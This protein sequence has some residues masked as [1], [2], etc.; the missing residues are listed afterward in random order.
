[1]PIFDMVERTM[2]KKLNFP[3]GIVLRLVART[4]YVGEILIKTLTFN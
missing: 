1:M 3:P 2:V 4:A